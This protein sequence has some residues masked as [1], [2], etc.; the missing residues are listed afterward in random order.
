V[1]EYSPLE[2]IRLWFGVY[3]EAEKFDT[4]VQLLLNL[5]LPEAAV[6]EIVSGIW[7]EAQDNVD[8]APW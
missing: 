5:P 6:R 2:S 1:S 8:Q 7:R 4:S 3:G